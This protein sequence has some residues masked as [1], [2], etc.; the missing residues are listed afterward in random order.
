MKRVTIL[1][2]L[3]ALCLA[4]F[5]CTSQPSMGEISSDKFSAVQLPAIILWPRQTWGFIR[6]SQAIYTTLINQI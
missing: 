4:L 6:C 5:G 2:L 1:F 3:A